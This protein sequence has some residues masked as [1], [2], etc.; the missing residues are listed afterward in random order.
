MVNFTNS[1]L[2]QLAGH[3]TIYLRVMS[4]RPMFGTELISKTNKQAK[5]VIKMNLKEN[6]G[7]FDLKRK[8]N[9]R[10]K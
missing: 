5:S 7:E 1:W 4:S 6:N 2:A 10:Y 9:H 8:K 3:V